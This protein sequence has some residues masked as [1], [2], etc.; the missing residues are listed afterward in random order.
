VGHDQGSFGGTH[1]GRLP[2]QVFD[3]HGR[4]YGPQSWAIRCAKCSKAGEGGRGAV[5]PI[6]LVRRISS[7]CAAAISAAVFLCAAAARN[8]YGTRRIG[9]VAL[10]KCLLWV[11]LV[12][13]TLR[14]SLPVFPNKQTF[15]RSVGMSQRCQ[16][17]TSVDHLVRTA[18][19]RWRNCHTK[20]FGRLKVDAENEFSRLFN[21]YVRHFG[22]SQELR[23]LPTTLPVDPIQ[24][25]AIGNQPA[26]FCSLRP[27]K[28]CR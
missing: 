25:R 27:L 10:G 23:N 14:C 11:N 15:S 13:L 4:R 3:S 1:L 6:S 21:R 16:H 28:D 9:P 18:D 24:T 8:F 7:T 12:G 17:Q 19:Q 20:C 5:S 22:T 26:V 2:L